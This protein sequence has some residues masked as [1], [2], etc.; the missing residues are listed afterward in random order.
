MDLR[1]PK[2]EIQVRFNVISVVN[3]DTVCSH[4]TLPKLN[5]T[6]LRGHKMT[7]QPQP[8][9][10]EDPQMVNPGKEPEKPKET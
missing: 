8:L 6:V 3:K 1:K 9:P 7:D 5:S 4:K 2:M 10:K